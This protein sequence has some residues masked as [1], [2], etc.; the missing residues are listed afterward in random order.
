MAMKPKLEVR[1]YH[2][3][4]K[5]DYGLFRADR[6]SP[7][8]VGITRAHAEHLKKLVGRMDDI[9]D[10]IPP[11]KDWYNHEEIVDVDEN[12]YGKQKQ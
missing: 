5:S 2:G 4:G 8:C 3:D 9:P 6:A 10:T 1:Q 7:I 12:G 11:I